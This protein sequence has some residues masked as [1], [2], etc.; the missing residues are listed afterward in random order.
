MN[1]CFFHSLLA[2]QSQ[3]NYLP[4]RLCTAI[5]SFF[6]ENGGN[7]RRSREPT[8]HCEWDNLNLYLDQSITKGWFQPIGGHVSHSTDIHSYCH[9]AGTVLHSKGLFTP[10]LWTSKCFNIL[11]DLLCYTG[12]LSFDNKN[13][14]EIFNSGRSFDKNISNVVSVLRLLMTLHHVVQGHYTDA[15][16]WMKIFVFDEN[17]TDV[18]CKGS[19]WH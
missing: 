3:A 9:W 5:V 4:L 11:W 7:S 6:L 2:H 14:F 17:F 10:K 19:N 12:N 13:I 18:C 1:V 8:I 16:S 15:F